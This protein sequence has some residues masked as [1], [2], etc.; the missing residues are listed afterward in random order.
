MCVKRPRLLRR[1]AWTHRADDQC[2]GVL[3][4]KKRADPPSRVFAIDLS[5]GGLATGPEREIEFAWQPDHVPRDH[6][7]GTKPSQSRC[8]RLLAVLD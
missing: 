6:R 4:V 5:G 8:A 1:R 3:V 7:H 2:R